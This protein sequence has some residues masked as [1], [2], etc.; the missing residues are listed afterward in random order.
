V[1]GMS[2][3]VESIWFK[4]HKKLSYLDK[5]IRFGVDQVLPRNLTVRYTGALIAVATLAISGQIIVQTSLSRQTDDQRRIRLIERQ[6]HDSEN[7]RK[8]V[9]SLQLSSRESQIKI[10]IELIESLVTQ[11]Q[12]NSENLK[13]YEVS[14][15]GEAHSPPEIVP[16][17]KKIDNSLTG[18]LESGRTLSSSSVSIQDH[19][20]MEA[21]HTLLS[22]ETVY[23]TSL[24]DVSKYY[25]LRLEQQV[26]K[27]K[28]IEL[29]L[30]FTTLLVLMIE[31]L[32]VFRPAV[33]SLYEALRI[34]SEFLGRMGH[35]MR[36]PMNSILGMTHLLYETPLTDQ[37]QKYL[38]ILKKS[39]TGLLEVLNNLLDFSSIESGSMKVESNPFDFYK[40]L[41][42][43]ID[44][45]V[46]GAHANGI[47]LIL[48]L[49]SDVPLKLCGD[50]VKLQQVL[51]NL[52]G[53]A[54]KFTKQ[55]EVTL[56]VQVQKNIEGTWIQ[57]EV[58]D[59]GI[60][61]EQEKMNKIFNPFVQEDSTVRRR[62]GGTGLGL[63]I[64]KD[65]V[66]LLGGVL[67]VESQKNLGSRFYFSLPVQVTDRDCVD[68]TIRKIGFGAYIAKI[69]EPNEAIVNAMGSLINRSGGEVMR[70][71]TLQDVFTDCM[72]IAQSS[73]K[74]EVFIVD[75][76][77]SKAAMPAFLSK[78]RKDSIKMD[79][80]VFLI[81]PTTSSLDIEKLSEYGIRNFIFK[82]IKPVQL[83]E[84]IEQGLTK[85]RGISSVRMAGQSQELSIQEI[86]LVRDPRP[87]RILAVDDSKDNQ[88]LIQAYLSALPY[89]LTFANQGRSA[90][91]KV[92]ASRFDLILMDLQMPEMDGYTAT[93]MIRDWESL[94]N[95]VPTPIIAV[96]AQ[97]NEAGSDR[98]QKAQ[99]SS[100]LAKPISPIQLR[101]VILDFTQEKQVQD[102]ITDDIEKQLA[103]LAPQY[104]SN[105]SREL[106]ELR[107]MLKE[108][109]FDKIQTLGHRLKGNAK[110]YGFEELGVIGAKLEE[111]AQK[112]DVDHIK[113]LIQESEI[114]LSRFEKEVP[115]FSQREASLPALNSRTNWADS[116]RPTFQ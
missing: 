18:M 36:N 78:V 13:S 19:E 104:L 103:D 9:L 81:K 8:A 110:S 14:A 59:T 17:L 69:I 45:A 52:L 112:Q 96:S 54:V 32:Y 107:A 48:D 1:K 111:S 65:L 75:Y 66:S 88:F 10:Q 71:K 7:L 2:E 106:G 114:Y 83:L 95:L 21:T 108:L 22:H 35:E 49:G 41:E 116:V 67:S 40:I 63:S 109:N 11:F 94:E 27:S 34:R 4:I 62:F 79:S 39:S 38:S 33:E 31:A 6:V 16:L 15:A 87:L 73:D 26:A 43:S 25:E 100:Y 74:K 68:D 29:L 91:E 50:P 3:M 5:K 30:L 55:G 47:E 53:N 86:R 12:K 42:R 44:L 20:L 113:I 23:R 64:S 93:R 61:I 98:F 82:P 24:S 28:G 58:I 57:F 72:P 99:F 92:K 76:E 97:D 105:R 101:R 84:A 70:L 56:R 77:F 46:Y 90:V 115:P 60:G 37:Q 102:N 89:R 51:S 85:Y 80:F